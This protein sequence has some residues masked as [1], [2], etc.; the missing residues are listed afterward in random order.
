M[1][2]SLLASKLGLIFKFM[3]NTQQLEDIRILFNKQNITIELDEH[4]NNFCYH[5]VKLLLATPN[6][7]LRLKIHFSTSKCI[8]SFKQFPYLYIVHTSLSP[9][10]NLPSRYHQWNE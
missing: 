1:A 10:T 8:I 6:Y 7:Y 3:F 4:I 9:T 2:E 5:P